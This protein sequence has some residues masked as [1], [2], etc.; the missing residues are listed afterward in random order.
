MFITEF[1]SCVFTIV[2]I[3]YS[4]VMPCMSSSI[5]SDVC[6]SSPEFGSSQN[7]YLGFIAIAR[8]IAA[9]FCIP[10]D[11]SSGLLSCASNRLTRS[12]HVRARL[13]RS[14]YVSDENMSSGNITF[15]ST[16]MESNNAAFWNSIPISWRMSSFSSLPN[17]IMLRPS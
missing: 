12:R 11:N 17:D 7:R 16:L 14:L 5:M 6:G 4:S 8:A 2:V 1:M 13:S 10:P 3:P 15:S 9:R